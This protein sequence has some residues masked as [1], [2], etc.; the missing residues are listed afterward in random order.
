MG[1]RADQT[2]RALA[3]IIL[4]MHRRNIDIGK[5]A[6]DRIE[7]GGEDATLSLVYRWEVFLDDIARSEERSRAP[8]YR[9]RDAIVAHEDALVAEQLAAMPTPKRPRARRAA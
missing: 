4:A 5:L 8:M 2:A 7:V 9:M 3:E 1:N 6:V